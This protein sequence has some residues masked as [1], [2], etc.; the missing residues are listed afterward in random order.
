MFVKFSV[1]FLVSLFKFTFLVFSLILIFTEIEVIMNLSI[2]NILFIQGY[3]LYDNLMSYNFDNSYL[4][5]LDPS[6]IGLT[7][8][9]ALA[10]LPEAL[11][12]AS[13]K[14]IPDGSSS[15]K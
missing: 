15:I 1:T 7:E 10:F 4:V 13:V 8:A 14:P 9:L 11:A 3:E 2:D 6:G 12:L 5:L